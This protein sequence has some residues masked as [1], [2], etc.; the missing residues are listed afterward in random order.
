M[1]V[2]EMVT[3][4]STVGSVSSS[5]VIGCCWSTATV[6]VVVT[7]ANP[8]L[9]DGE[10]NRPGADVDPHLHPERRSDTSSPRRQSPHPARAPQT[11]VTEQTIAD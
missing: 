3:V 8:A 11:A 9:S 4:S 10:F 5:I 7:D 2:A 1:R 6:I